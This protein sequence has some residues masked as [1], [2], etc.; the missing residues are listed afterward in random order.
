MSQEKNSNEPRMDRVFHMSGKLEDLKNDTS[1]WLKKSP[2]ER[3]AA[4]Y[5][6]TCSAYGLEYRAD[7][8]LD[9]SVYGSRKHKN[10]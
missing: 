2:F 1:Y 6:L 3:L 4:A 8:K 7:H 5:Y 10:L 9:R